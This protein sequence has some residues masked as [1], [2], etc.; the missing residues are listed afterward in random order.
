MNQTPQEDIIQ[1]NIYPK[2]FLCPITYDIMQ[3]PVIASD[4]YTYERSAIMN[5][6]KNNNT[7]PMTGLKIVTN[8]S[9][10][11]SNFNLKSN[12]AS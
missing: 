12:I 8:S 10:L 3:D 9:K 7:S 6:I 5:W 2:H 11:I 4:G 1:D